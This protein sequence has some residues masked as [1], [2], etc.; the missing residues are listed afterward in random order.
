MKVLFVGE[1]D[2]DVGK[3]SFAPQP[4][5]AAGVVSTL[6]R[7][8]VP[9]ISTDSV[10]IKRDRLPLTGSRKKDPLVQKVI[11]AAELAARH[12]C[13]A[14]VFVHDLD[15]QDVIQQRLRDGQQ[16]ACESRP[17]HPVVIG[18]AVQSIEA[19]TLGA[20]S[21]LKAVLQVSDAE[22]DVIYRPTQ[23]ETYF[24][25]SGK[26]EHQAR[27]LLEQVA[28][29]GH[30][31]AGTEFRERVAA[32]TDIDELKRNCPQGFKAFA[33]ELEQALRSG[34]RKMEP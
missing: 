22:L 23:V 32:E 20:R 31:S 25:S 19:W 4:S 10:M 3:S 16:M 2:H 1:G 34:H 14:T 33:G 6:A 8:V 7:K 27:R 29:L 28:Q 17:G 18:V 5:P 24:N 9:E 30:S 13:Q 11:A 26:P 12:G 15:R 21:G